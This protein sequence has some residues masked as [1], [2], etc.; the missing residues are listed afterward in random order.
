MSKVT[1][2][3]LGLAGV[4]SAAWWMG[5]MMYFI[6]VAKHFRDEEKNENAKDGSASNTSSRVS[7]WVKPDNKASAPVEVH[8]PTKY[9]ERS[10]DK[11]PRGVDNLSAKWRSYYYSSGDNRPKRLGD[12]GWNN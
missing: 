1:K 11:F 3:I 10:H 4:M 5:G 12:P 2:A 6:M 8:N 7:S 9:P